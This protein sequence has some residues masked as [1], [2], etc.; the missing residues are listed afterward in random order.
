M[1]NQLNPSELNL[2]LTKRKPVKNVSITVG[3]KNPRVR[4]VGVRE[5]YDEANL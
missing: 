4:I 1:A 3:C 2:R 5:Y